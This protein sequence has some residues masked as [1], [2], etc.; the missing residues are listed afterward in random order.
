MG[1]TIDAESDWTVP[2]PDSEVLAALANLRIWNMAD[3]FENFAADWKG[4]DAAEGS[5]V[6]E[7]E[8]I[9]EERRLYLG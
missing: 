6:H 2:M 3:E 7:Y 4:T 9:M 8:E 1:L 5:V